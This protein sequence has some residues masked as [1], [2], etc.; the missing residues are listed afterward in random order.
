MPAHIVFRQIDARP[1]GFSP[2]WL[3]RILRDELQFE[4]LVFSDDLSMEGA[5]TFGGIQDRARAALEAG[6][7]MVLVCNDAE[8]VD[9]LYG[10]FVHLMPP[11]SLARLARLHG[12][13][14]AE[15]MVQL[16]ADPRYVAAVKATAGLG[17][18]DGELPLA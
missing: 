5:K 1:A 13:S 6:C 7:D 3:R 17:Q 11:V 16:R 2:V 14:G 4:G 15:T 12:R 8:A 9:E 10:S 18:A